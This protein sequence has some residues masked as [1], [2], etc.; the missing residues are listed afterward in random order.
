VDA[1]S[2]QLATS[3]V[4]GRR[5]RLRGAGAALYRLRELRAPELLALGMAV[6]V[7]GIMFLLMMRFQVLATPLAVSASGNP[8]RPDSR[9]VGR[10]A[11]WL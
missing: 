2:S 5:V 9:V 8:V 6:R 10:I 7:G 3:G 4:P 11:R 1:R